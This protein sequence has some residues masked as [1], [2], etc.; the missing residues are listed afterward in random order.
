MPITIKDI[1]KIAGVSYATVSRAL[2]NHPEVSLKTKERILSIAQE[3]GYSPNE[4]ARGLVKQS[5]N[6]IGLLVPD[7]SNP[8][9]PEVAKGVEEKAMSNDYHVFLCNTDW[10]SKKE[11]DYITTLRDKRVG[12][13]IIAPTSIETY[14]KIKELN[15]SVPVVFIGSKSDEKD[16]NYVVIDNEKAGFIAAEYLISLGFSEIAY[17]CGSENSVANSDRLTGYNKAI[18]S[19]NLDSWIYNMKGSSFRRES[20]YRAASEAIK[21]GSLPQALICANDIVA[22]SAIEAFEN[23]GYDVPADISVMGFDDI[24]YAA[25]HKINLTTVAQP[26]Y[27]IGSLAAQIILDKVGNPSGIGEKITLEP[28]LV[29]RGTC[30]KY[31]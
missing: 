13:I 14:K 7:I 6:T 11:I 3:H 1:A 25:L 22:I 15:L 20:G 17:L 26:K 10:D 19:H 21:S 5:T 18:E 9:F 2:N 30:K 24:A 28:A 8:F 16:I 31:S 29:K 12:G 4:I 23:N 27:E